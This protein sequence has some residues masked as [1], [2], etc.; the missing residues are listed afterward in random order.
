MNAH[1]VMK[2]K[3]ISTVPLFFLAWA[4]AGGS[5]ALA[6]RTERG[7]GGSKAPVDPPF[8]LLFIGS[9]T[10]LSRRGPAGWSERSSHSFPGKCS[11][12]SR[13]RGIGPA[14]PGPPTAARRP[15]WERVKTGRRSI[16]C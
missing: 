12:P 3:I 5:L 13:R 7:R 1:R 8:R 10:R 11:A 16:S 15:S 9:S 2:S 4:D 6:G 14:S